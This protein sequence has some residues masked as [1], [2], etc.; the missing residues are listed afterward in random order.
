M[1]KFLNSLFE[2]DHPSSF[3]VEELPLEESMKS[4]FENPKK[5]INKN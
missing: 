4:F 1:T 2:I 5:F 3:S